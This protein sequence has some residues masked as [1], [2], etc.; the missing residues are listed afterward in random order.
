MWPITKLCFSPICK[1]LAS[2]ATCFNPDFWTFYALITVLAVQ[3]LLQVTETRERTWQQSQMQLR[4][5]AGQILC[6]KP[7][8]NSLGVKR[9]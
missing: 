2:Y 4:D 6:L 3:T 1:E 8:M 9:P 5:V 7:D